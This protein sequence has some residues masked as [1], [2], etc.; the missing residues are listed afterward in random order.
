M[1]N[2]PKMNE[3]QLKGYAWGFNKKLESFKER[4]CTQNELYEVMREALP[5]M[6]KNKAIFIFSP[7]EVKQESLMVM[8]KILI[9]MFEKP[10]QPIR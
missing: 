3:E 8:S 7:K 6:A 9:E 2:I 5:T 4:G 10:C 1:D